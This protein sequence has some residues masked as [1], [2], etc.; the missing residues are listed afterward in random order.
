M[1]VRDAQ[2]ILVLEGRGSRMIETIVTFSERSITATDNTNGLTVKSFPYDAVKHATFSRSRNPRG[3]GG[4]E[5]EVPGGIPQGNVFS[6]GPR[7]WVTIE[8]AGDRL[9]LRLDPPAVRPLL[10]LL[11]QRTKAPLERYEDP[12]KP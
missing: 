2:V 7:L 8:T 4:A 12:E 3:A 10:D 11:Q 6:R 9:V 5:I 1:I